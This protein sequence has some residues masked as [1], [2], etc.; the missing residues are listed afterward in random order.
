MQYGLQQVFIGQDYGGLLAGFFNVQRVEPLGYET[1]L[2]VIGRCLHDGETGLMH[3]VK[4]LPRQLVGELPEVVTQETSGFMQKAALRVCR[5]IIPVEECLAGL[6][7]GTE[8]FSLGSVQAVESHE[9]V[10]AGSEAV[11]VKITYHSALNHAVVAYAFV[12]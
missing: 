5:I 2:G 9:C 6:L 3:A 10:S 11:C 4:P 12:V 8:Q 1:S 7:Y